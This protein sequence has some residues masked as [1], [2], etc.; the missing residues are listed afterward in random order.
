MY[1]VVTPRI[2]MFVLSINL[3][4]ITYLYCA[5]SVHAHVHYA[6]HLGT[7]AEKSCEAKGVDKNNP[8]DDVSR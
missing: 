8:Q 3:F 6:Y 7:L 1:L 5:F 2:V 4:S